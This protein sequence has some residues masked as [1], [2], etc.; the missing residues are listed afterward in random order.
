[1][2][3]RE[4]RHHHH[5]DLGHVVELDPELDALSNKVG[6]RG[7]VRT[8]WLW[9]D[10]CPATV[11]GGRQTIHELIERFLRTEIR[12]LQAI[13][14][15]RQQLA[16]GEGIVVLQNLSEGGGN[17]EAVLAELQHV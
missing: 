16:A 10:G 7:G 14:I 13:G 4:V 17:H 12:A 3:D 6:L 9:H 11:E 1:M 8:G 2:I 5:N 15:Q